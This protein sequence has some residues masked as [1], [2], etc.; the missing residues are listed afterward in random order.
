[1]NLYNDQDLPGTNYE[2]LFAN[3]DLL[4]GPGTEPSGNSLFNMQNMQQL[5]SLGQ[6]TPNILVNSSEV[7]NSTFTLQPE[8]AT[9]T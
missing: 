9:L 2:H 4:L 3:Y 6:N 7:F 1:V 5:V 8:W